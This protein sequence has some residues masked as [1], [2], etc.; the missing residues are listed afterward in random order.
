[1]V[2]TRFVLIVVLLLIPILLSAE[3]PV[4]VVERSFVP[5]GPYNWRGAKT[6]ALV[7]TIWFPAAPNSK[8]TT[9][10]IGSP[11]SPFANAGT[12]ARGADIAAQPDRFPLIVVSHGTGGSSGMMGW[13]GT[14]LAA[15]GYIVAAVNHPGNNAREAYTAQGFS[16]WWERARDLTNVI[17]QMLQDPTF[18]KRIDTGRIGAAGFSL[19]GYTMIEIAGGLSNPERY[20]QFCKSK[21]ADGMCV[22]PLEFPDLEAKLNEDATSDPAIQQSIAHS[23]DSYRDSRVSAVFAIA[24][25]LGPSFDPGS[26]HKIS[27]PVEIVTGD[28]DTIVPVSSSAKFFSQN[29]PKSKLTLLPGVGHY[30][31]LGTCSDQAKKTTPKLCVDPKGVDRDSAHKQVAAIAVKFFELHFARS[32]AN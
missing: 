1:M 28:A 20:N 31:F 9:Q 17:D 16:L 18:A 30:T 8:E 25:A 10:W 26:L 22:P 15:H 7:T 2:K 21:Q 5:K 4:G 13:L 32:T 11:D 6:H 19:G 27:I 12:A 23:S 29:I 14:E 3:N 24:P